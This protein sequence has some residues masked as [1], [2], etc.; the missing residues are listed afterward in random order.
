MDQN[1][2][3]YTG[4][5]AVCLEELATGVGDT[6]PPSL[7]T[8]IA[9]EPLGPFDPHMSRDHGGRHLRLLPDPA[10]AATVAAAAPGEETTADGGLASVSHLPTYIPTE[11]EHD[12]GEGED[13]GAA[14]PEVDQGTR[15][16]SDGGL[17]GQKD[18]EDFTRQV[19]AALP[20][21][22]L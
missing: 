15:P 19:A 20:V 21:P 12:G 13:R 4:V 22:R 7:R 8:P 9:A 16:R 18:E 1:V 10:V 2:R 14:A 6:Q 3:R 5:G 11:E 17:E